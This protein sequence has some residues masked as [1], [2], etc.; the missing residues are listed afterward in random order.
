MNV[1]CTQ[2]VLECCMHFY[3]E[4][5]NV[6]TNRNALVFSVNSWWW[7]KSAKSRHDSSNRTL[8]RCV[9]VS[10]LGAFDVCRV[11]RLFVCFKR[12]KIEQCRLRCCYQC[13][14]MWST[15]RDMQ[16]WRL[17]TATHNNKNSLFITRTICTKHDRLPWPVRCI[18]SAFIRVSFDSSVC[19]WFALICG[20]FFPVFWPPQL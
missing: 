1:I 15:M 14:V 3:M 9:M 12:W 5:T 19:I 6:Q 16:A 4:T 18:A 2:I 13:E 10:M 17:N 20:V 11:P 7:M 8:V